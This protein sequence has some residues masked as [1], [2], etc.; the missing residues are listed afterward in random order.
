MAPDVDWHTLEL[1][2]FNK[3]IDG[4]LG[5]TLSEAGR[6]TIETESF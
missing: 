1:L 4:L 3:I 5:F 2:E 6:K